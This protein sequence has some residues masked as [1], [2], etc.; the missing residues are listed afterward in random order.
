M[1]K[2]AIGVFILSLLAVPCR[3]GPVF[4]TLGP[5]DTY[6]TVA[7][8]TIGRSGFEYDQGFQF[9]FTG[10]SPYFFNTIELA[11]GR[12]TG[13]NQLEVWLMSDALGEPDT[14]I[15]K[16]NVGA[17]GLFGQ[18]N[19]LLVGHSV[20]HPILSPGTNYWLIASAPNSDTWAG[21]NHSSPE[22]LGTRASRQG[23]GP[24]SVLPDETLG[25]FRVSGTPIPAPGVFVLGG[26]G[27][28][29]VGWLRRRRT[30]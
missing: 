5:G 8:Y 20:L 18:N 15:E 7:G 12:F 3:A 9:S 4:S 30:L 16:L 29:L 2:K 10:P 28:G 14:V 19:P 21:F 24:W 25:A 13:T 27:V 6:N 1:K 23:T 26:M 22:V 17:M 11:A